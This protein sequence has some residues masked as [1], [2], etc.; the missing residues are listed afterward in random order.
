MKVEK[1]L[2]PGSTLHELLHFKGEDGEYMDPTELEVKIRDAEGNVVDSLSKADLSQEDVGRWILTYTLTD[3][4]KFGVWSYNVKWVHGAIVDSGT[5]CFSVYPVPYGSLTR[6][7]QLTSVF[8]D[9]E[10]D[11][12]LEA[13]NDATAYVNVKLKRLV[14]VPLE[15]VPDEIRKATNFLAASFV[16]KVN[17]PDE[18]VHPYYQIAMSIIKSYIEFLT[19]EAGLNEPIMKYTSKVKY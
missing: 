9:E 12:L 19:D 15:V 8:D 2:H 3:A 5:F 4:A 10:D 6:V 13:L 16:M 14:D 11:K 18:E 7:R 1:Q 17:S